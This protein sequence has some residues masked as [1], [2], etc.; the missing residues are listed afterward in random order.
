MKKR[1]KKIIILIIISLTIIIRIYIA[2]N[3]HYAVK[4]IEREVNILDFE[5]NA[6]LDNPPTEE[7]YGH[8]IGNGVSI[9]IGNRSEFLDKVDNLDYG[10]SVVNGLNESIKYLN[11][12]S[13]YNDGEIEKYYYF[14]KEVIDILYGI[15]DIEIFKKFFNDLNNKNY[16]YCE[17]KLDTLE[18]NNNVFTFNIELVSDNKITIP[19]KALA[20]D[21]DDMIARLYFYN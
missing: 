12:I 2:N 8:D 9:D 14:N 17:I 4:D 5:S 6:Q 15:K 11:I 13:E 1:R 16:I 7:K 21:N 19:I 20:K 18:V 3:R 10:L